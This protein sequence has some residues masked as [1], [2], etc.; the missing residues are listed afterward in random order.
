MQLPGRRK[1][2]WYSGGIQPPHLAIFRRRERFSVTAWEKRNLQW[3]TVFGASSGKTKAKQKKIAPQ[4]PS[5]LSRKRFWLGFS[6]QGKGCKCVAARTIHRRAS[7]A[8]RAPTFP[9]NALQRLFFHPRRCAGTG[10]N[11]RWDYP[12]EAIMMPPTG[13][14]ETTVFTRH[15]SNNTGNQNHQSHSPHP[16]LVCP[17]KS[18]QIVPQHVQQSFHRIINETAIHVSIDRGNEILLFAL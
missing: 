11:S 6:K 9:G 3:N 15:P 12:R 1:E 10:E 16:S 4:A 7:A 17:R 5:R 2:A 14:N 13:G 8:M 18:R